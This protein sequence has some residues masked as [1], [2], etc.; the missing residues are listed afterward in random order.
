MS[1]TEGQGSRFSVR[2]VAL[3]IAV[4]VFSLSGLAVL[5]AYA[6]DLRKGDDGGAHALSRSAVGFAAATRLLRDTGRTVLLSRGPLHASD[7]ALLILTPGPQHDLDAI[8]SLHHD[9]ATLVVLPKWVTTAHPTHRGWVQA[10]GLLPT[11]AVV[12]PLTAP[13]ADS[14][15]VESPPSSPPVVSRRPGATHPRLM[16]PDGEPIGALGEVTEL[17]TLSGPEWIPV[18]VDESGGAVLAMNRASHLYVLADPDLL[19][20]QGL[21]QPPSAAAALRMVDLI[22]PGDGGIIFDVTLPGF[23]RPRS[24]LRLMLEPPLL[25]A[26]LALLAAAALVAFQAAVRFG[27]GRRQGRAIALGKRALADNSAGLIR[28]AGREHSMAD[29]YARMVRAAVTRAIGA[30]RNL[31]GEALDAFLDRLGERLGAHQTYSALAAEA[32]SAKSPGELVRIA[33]NLHRWKLEMTRG[34]Q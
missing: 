5:S 14:G 10:A 21:R 34:R 8:E 24:I 19:N 17:Q 16:R 25:G 22:R 15:D 27:P 13:E 30:P 9:G 32:R 20:T 23:S 2:T 1:A 12:R 26:T 11:Q 28:L 7:E 31:D 33:R 29:P 3:L 4:C 6:P 18:V